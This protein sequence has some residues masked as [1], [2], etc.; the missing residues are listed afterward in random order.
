MPSLLSCST[1]A[2]LT[3]VL[4]VVFQRFGEDADDLA[5]LAHLQEQPREP[6]PENTIDCVR[7][8][9][10][11][12]MDADDACIVSRSSGALEE[13]I[14][15]VVHVCDAFDLTVYQKKTEIMYMPARHMLQEVM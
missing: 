15:I 10:W 7:Q 5:E 8:A 13:Y 3:V 12:I 11:G 4:L 6:R 9:I 1:Y 14:D 2:P